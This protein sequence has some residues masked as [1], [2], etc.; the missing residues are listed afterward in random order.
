MKRTCFQNFVVALSC[1]AALLIPIHAAEAGAGELSA[2][3]SPTQDGALEEIIV[4]AQKRKERLA[5]VPIAITELSAQTLQDANIQQVRELSAAVPGLQ[6]QTNNGFVQPVIRGIS[7]TIGGSANG[8]NVGVYVDGFYLPNPLTL[9]TQFLNVSDVQVLKGPQ[10][11]LFGRNTAG[12]AILITTPDPSLTPN[13]AVQVSYGSYNA[14]NVQ[15]YGDLPISNSVAVDG[16]VLYKTGGGWITNI[17]DED[18]PEANDL[19]E[20]LGVKFFI[21]DDLTVLIRGSYSKIN[22]PYQSLHAVLCCNTAGKPYTGDAFFSDFGLPQPAIATTP[23]RG[24]SDIRPVFNSSSAAVQ[25]TIK[26]NLG[27]ADLTSY[28]QYR[29]EDAPSAFD[30]ALSSIP[31][32]NIALTN[33]DRILTQE[34][35]L[36]S[37]PETPLQW[38][39]GLYYF[40][41]H[42]S[43]T[44]D[45]GT[46]SFGELEHDNAVASSLA[47]YGDATYQLTPQWFLTAGLRYGTDRYTDAYIDPGPPVYAE[48]GTTRHD[49]P[50]VTTDKATPRAVVRFKP[51]ETSSVYASFSEGFKAGLQNVGSTQPSPVKPEK[52]N[53]YEV[54]YKLDTSRRSINLDAFYYQ[55]KDLQVENYTA[56]VAYILN[57]AN[58]RIKGVEGDFHYAYDQHFTVYGALG[59]T[60]AVYEQYDGAPYYAQCVS[61]ATCGAGLGS[62][63]VIP[64]NVRNGAMPY[65]PKWQG[66]IGARYTTEFARGKLMLSATLSAA[67]KEWFD[68]VEEFHNTSHEDLGLRAEWL[69]PSGHYTIAVYGDNLTDDRYIS[70]LS[71][72]SIAVPIDYSPPATFGISLLAKF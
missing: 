21:S 53:A 1:S 58:S 41:D 26:A 8:S 55:Y 60:E 71:T 24:S 2:S 28:S 4:T 59:F 29:N 61:I 27:F 25:A 72:N 32:F 62:F 39:T 34:F 65:A 35:V 45:A 9:D 51:T 56:E 47:A 44:S 70:Y 38:T 5:D 33:Y 52:I 67:S 7:A 46:T 69:D 20:R 37:K 15:A 30:L 16:A 63:A 10:G 31:Y 36:T 18:R 66:N 40:R 57:A 68:S 48:F 12:G 14:T 54:G 11:T 23:D 22:E 3:D 6:F 64:Q 17:V 13:A 49:Y 50:S 43:V 19:S 42:A